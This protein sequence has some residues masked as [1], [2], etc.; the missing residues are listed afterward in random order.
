MTTTTTTC[1]DAV[2]ALL[3]QFPDAEMRVPDV[4]A[5]L[6]GAWPEADVVVAL[7]ALVAAQRVLRVNDA[8]TLWYS[9]SPQLVP[10]S[11]WGQE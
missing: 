2:L 7:D 6:D 5:E 10:E 4:T 1:A 3:A 11:A 8:G 9:L